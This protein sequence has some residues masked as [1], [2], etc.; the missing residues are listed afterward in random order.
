M[1]IEKDGVLY[2]V[3]I[4]AASAVRPRDAQPIVN[5]QKK[6]GSIMGP[7]LVIHA[8]ERSTRLSDTCIAVPFDALIQTGSHWGRDKGA[9]GQVL[10]YENP[11]SRITDQIQLS[12]TRPGN[13]PKCLRLP[14]IS[15]EL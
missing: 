14:L 7:G 11:G 9:W 4:R 8:G 3:E 6:L 12:A 1:L 13:R 10:S 2:P 5:L 15:F